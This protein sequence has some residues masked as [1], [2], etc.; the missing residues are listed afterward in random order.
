MTSAMRYLLAPFSSATAQ[1][2]VP[3]LTLSGLVI[4]NFQFL[5]AISIRAISSVVEHL[6]HT[7]GV[8]GSIPASRRSFYV[9]KRRLR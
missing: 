3:L 7:Q 8:A 5:I 6:L 1:N 4:F 9:C 2:D